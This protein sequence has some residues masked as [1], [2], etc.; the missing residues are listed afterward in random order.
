MSEDKKVKGFSL[1]Y[2]FSAIKNKKLIDLL[3]YKQN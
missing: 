1:F 2:A 3:T